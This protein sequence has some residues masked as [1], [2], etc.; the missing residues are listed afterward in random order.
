MDDGTEAIRIRDERAA[1]A[2]AQVQSQTHPN[3]PEPKRA[4]V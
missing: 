4:R 3:G 2:A 1:Q